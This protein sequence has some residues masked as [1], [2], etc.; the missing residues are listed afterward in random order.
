[1]KKL[2]FKHEKPSSGID[3]HI[4][5]Y[6]NPNTSSGIIDVLIIFFIQLSL[7]TGLFFIAAEIFEFHYDFF[8]IILFPIPLCAALCLRRIY[9]RFPLYIAAALVFIYAA[10]IFLNRSI[11][12]VQLQSI[13]NSLASGSLDMS[14]MDLTGFMAVFMAAVLAITFFIVFI[15]KKGWIIGFISFP[16]VLLGPL[17]GNEPNLLQIVCLAIFHFGDHIIRH[18]GKN[19]KKNF[20]SSGRLRT[21]GSGVLLLSILAGTMFL[22]SYLID[23]DAMESLLEIPVKIENRI[24][25]SGMYLLNIEK[26]HGA[27]SRGNNYPSGE[28]RLEVVTTQLP[29][30]TVYLKNFTGG[31]YIGNEWLPADES[32]LLEFVQN[33]GDGLSTVI[34]WYYS[35]PS[36]LNSLQYEYIQRSRSSTQNL[37]Y[38]QDDDSGFYMYDMEWSASPWMVITSARD[39]DQSE[40]LPYVSNYG[41]NYA[42]R[43]WYYYFPLNDLFDELQ[44]T[45]T[46]SYQYFTQVMGPYEEYAFRNYL[47]VPT[48]KLPRLSELAEQRTSTTVDESVD[49]IRRTLHSRAVYTRRPEMMPFGQDIVES[50]LFDRHQG[51]CQ[52]FASA[53][54]LL[55]RMYGIPARYVTGYA[56][57]REE[58]ETIP[59][60]PSSY[61]AVLT[62]ENAHAWAEIYVRNAG[63]IP[64]EV[65]PPPMSGEETV[66]PAASI[67]TVSYNSVNTINENTGGNTSFVDSDTR[68]VSFFLWRIIAIFAAMIIFLIILPIRRAII[69]RQTSNMKCDMLFSHFLKALKQSGFSVDY[70]CTEDDLSRLISDYLPKTDIDIIKA[71]IDLASR[72]AFSKHGLSQ[73]QNKEA[74]LMYKKLISS[75]YQ[76][77]APFKKLKFKYWNAYI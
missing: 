21:A 8:E 47:S 35:R 66:P 2:S 61:R 45:D 1:M 74:L 64:I 60:D 25:Q 36:Q 52:H 9:R 37:I 40:Y 30:E 62:D 20:F 3:I 49:D 34:S 57:S 12:S 73:K 59:D 29:E 5:G 28:K 75:I 72:S 50:F 63:W 19:T 23:G 44:N 56:V 18:T 4:N 16:S 55:F 24:R 48:E 6:Q 10:V 32:A 14:G 58:F 41:G 51:Y 53:A 71:F 33:S 67:F 68:Y 31:D 76:K 22:L 77:L 42:N 26:N 39:T 27:V 7:Y 54:V 65:T 46:E 70:N 11:L 15:L 69:L 38:T 17:F 43:Q 13:I